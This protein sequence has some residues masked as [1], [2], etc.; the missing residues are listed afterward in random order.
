VGRTQEKVRVTVSLPAAVARQLDEQRRGLDLNRSEAVEEAVAEWVRR[1]IET[2]QDR[3]TG[4]G[5][6]MDQQTHVLERATRMAAEIVLEA[7]R[8]QF[9]HLQEFGSDELSRRAAARLRR[10]ELCR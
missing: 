3:I 8:H 7:L 10:E 2:D 5:D 6:R 4:F 9:P 1:R